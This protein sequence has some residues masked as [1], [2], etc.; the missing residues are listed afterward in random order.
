M[1]F[2]VTTSYNPSKELIEIAKKLAIEYDVR[3]LNRNHLPKYLKKGLID[4]YYVIDKKKMLSIKW[5]DGEFFFHQGIAKIRMENI[6]HGE[7]DYLIES[8]NPSENDVVYDATC[9]LGSDALLIANYAKKVIAT[10]GSV[11]IYRVVKWGL[12][13]YVSEEEWINKSKEKIELLNENYKD[14]IRK[15]EERAFDVVYCDPMFE[16]PIYESNSLNPLRSF[17]LYEPL[18]KDDLEE[19]LRISKKKVVIKT[20]KKDNLYKEIRKYFDEEYVSRKS[21]VVYGVINKTEV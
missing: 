7:R 2:V 8:I 5:R 21:G 6:R 4:F 17:A 3:Y 20:L 18:T 19:M 1:N 14:F 13:N 9:G 10:E 16:N 12:S 15:V 11:H